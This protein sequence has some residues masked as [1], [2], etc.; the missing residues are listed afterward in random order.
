[1]N[2]TFGLGDGVAELSRLRGRQLG[3]NAVVRQADHEGVMGLGQPS[4]QRIIVRLA[5]HDVDDFAVATESRGC[6]LHALPPACPLVTLGSLAARPGRQRR[7]FQRS[8][9][10][11]VGQCQ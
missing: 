2:H 4:E 1:M 10:S 8:S 5:I 6:T 7:Q 9:P 11:V 3:K